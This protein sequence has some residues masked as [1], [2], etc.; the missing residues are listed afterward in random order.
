MNIYISSIF[1]NRVTGTVT[2]YCDMHT[3]KPQLAGFIIHHSG[4][5]VLM[6]IMNIYRVN[7][8]A[9]HIALLARPRSIIFLLFCCLA[10]NNQYLLDNNLL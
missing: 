6:G 5:S 2:F 7:L 8:S 9:E 10:M 1:N 4:D 3:G